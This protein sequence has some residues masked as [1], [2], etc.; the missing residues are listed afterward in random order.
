MNVE[1]HLVTKLRIKVRAI[2]TSRDE[3]KRAE[4]AEST[5]YWDHWQVAK[6]YYICRT[7]FCSAAGIIQSMGT[8]RL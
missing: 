7:V 6:F 1:R 4:T 2:R 5:D 8:P 3:I